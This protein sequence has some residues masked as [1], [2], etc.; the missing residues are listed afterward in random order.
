MSEAVN[1][2]SKYG[3][4]VVSPVSAAGTNKA[5]ATQLFGENSFQTVMTV[6]AGSGVQLPKIRLPASVT[7][8]NND[9]NVLLVYPDS[10][11]TINSLSADVGF[12]VPA[13]S[14]C[15]FQASGSK[16]WFTTGS[17]G[18]TG[19]LPAIPTGE[20]LSNVTGVSAPPVANT[21][22]SIIDAAIASVQGDILYRSATFW[23]ALAPGPAG[24]VL[25]SQGAGANPAW[26][27]AVSAY[28]T[29]NYTYFG[30]V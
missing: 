19:F 6:P 28:S 15:T 12:S 17:T 9:V 25:T 16:S 13:G 8:Y 21:L 27:A 22:T 14:G 26:S 1:T 3:Y 2:N 24:F 5:T 18:S 20:V 23:T 7:V 4:V 11:S 10:G 30:G 29:F